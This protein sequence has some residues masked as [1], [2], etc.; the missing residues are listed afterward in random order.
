MKYFWNFDEHDNSV[1]KITTALANSNPWPFIDKSIILCKNIDINKWHLHLN[2]PDSSKYELL[3]HFD[4]LLNY[5]DP[6]T[7]ELSHSNSTTTWYNLA[8]VESPVNATATIMDWRDTYFRMTKNTSTSKPVNLGVLKHGT[9]TWEFVITI[10]NHSDYS[11][12][13]RTPDIVSNQEGAGYRLTMYNRTDTTYSFGS[14]QHHNRS[15]VTKTFTTKNLNWGQK[16]HIVYEYTN[17]THN[18]TLYVNGVYID[19]LNFSSSN[20]TQSNALTSISSNPSTSTVETSS[21]NTIIANYFVIRYYTRLLTEAEIINNYNY[22]KRR[23]NIP[24]G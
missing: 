19:S 4:A 5:K 22:E 18:G 12:S 15:W 8:P 17:S 14:S 23:Y 21:F 1:N 11:N 7:G 10:Y 3:R 13:N 6:N 2:Y 24:E 16:Y 20:I 9:F